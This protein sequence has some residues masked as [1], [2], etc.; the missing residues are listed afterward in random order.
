MLDV[1]QN[2][3][4]GLFR[5]KELGG[6]P[7]DFFADDFFRIVIRDSKVGF[8]QAEENAVRGLTVRET[9]AF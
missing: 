5:R 4:G 1:R 7:F 8:E 9:R 2:I 3:R 6:N